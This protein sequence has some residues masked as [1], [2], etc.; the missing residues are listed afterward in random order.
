MSDSGPP[1][2]GGVTPNLVAS[3]NAATLNPDGSLSTSAGIRWLLIGSGSSPQWSLST[4]GDALDG[5][6]KA[7]LSTATALTDG[8][9][10]TASGARYWLAR[11]DGSRPIAKALPYA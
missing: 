5:P 11:Y 3:I 1:P 10:Q 6:T 4:A 7:L 2:V 8:S 9:W